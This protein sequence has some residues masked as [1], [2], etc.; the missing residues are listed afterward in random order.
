MTF[1]EIFKST[2]IALIL[3][4]CS[5]LF[6]QSVP[7]KI[8]FADM[9]LKLTREAINDIQ[10]DVNALTRSEK[11]FQMILER[12]DTY[13]PIIERILREEGLPD[14]FKYLV[15]QESALIGDAVS[16]SNAVGYWQFKE[17]SALENDLRIDRYVDERMNIVSATRAAAQYLINHNKNF[18]NWAYSLIA[19]QRGVVGAK[20]VIDKRYFGAKK[21]PITK[22]T[23]WYLKKYLAHKVAF[24]SVLGTSK[25]LYQ[26][27]ED[28]QVNGLSLKDISKKHQV[29]EELLEEYNKWIRRGNV[30]NDKNYVAVIPTIGSA[31]VRPLTASKA[32]VSTSPQFD[33][34]N[35]TNDRALK[36]AKKMAKNATI[37]HELKLNGLK[38]IVAA[39][40]Y[41]VASLAEKANLSERKFR[42]LNDMSM[43]QKLIVGEIYYTERK[44]NR[45]KYY[46]HT[47]QEGENMWSISQ[48]YGLKL[49][50]L[51]RKNRMKDPF[52]PK[53]G[54]VLWL[55][56]NRPSTI[57]VE[58]KKVTAPV[59]ENKAEIVEEKVE[60]D[61]KAD[62]V[63]NDETEKVVVAEVSNKADSPAIPTAVF[64]T[65][66]NTPASVLSAEEP[67]IEKEEEEI[68]D[69]EI[70]QEI[71]KPELQE[72]T[73]KKGDTFFSIANKFN[74]KISELLAEN[75]LSIK[76][77]LSV[78]QVVKV[79]KQY[80]TTEKSPI[81]EAQAEVKETT[82]KDSSQKEHKV[83]AGETMYAIARQYNVSIQQL[84]EWNNK[85]DYNLKEGEVIIINRK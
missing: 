47:V 78:G 62:N 82:S 23:Y 6:A 85:T 68:E 66:K 83:Q 22:N 59:V 42:K 46:Y 48:K 19:Y 15:I 5:S 67:K 80:G 70:E 16:S 33:L 84:L 28:D 30:P 29:S 49:H 55:R 10:S 57:A 8:E 39:K 35:Y 65:T 41:T 63:I 37:A 43:N 61:T 73:I 56:L 34:A 12:V 31:S 27:V 4:S 17:I 40:G 54:R 71:Q 14:D 76:E 75:N 24:E 52:K 53:V 69:Q 25:P 32:E 45:A 74:M 64:D 1:K 38:A 18:D 81:K 21:M 79:K 20:D 7:H 2:L 72:Y 50:K 36:E 51:Y 9:E 26:L 44:L 58:Y 60:A 13:M 77:P 3:S 11:Y